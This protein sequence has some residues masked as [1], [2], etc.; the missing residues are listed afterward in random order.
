M[1]NA[2][3]VKSLMSILGLAPT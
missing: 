2:T 1:A 3:E